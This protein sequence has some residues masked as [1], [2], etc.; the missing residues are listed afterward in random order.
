MFW[1]YF[2]L[3][4]CKVINQQITIIMKTTNLF[5][6]ILS[7]VFI[8]SLS[9]CTQETNLDQPDE[10]SSYKILPF[11]QN[12]NTVYTGNYK[13][14]NQT[15]SIDIA[16]DIIDLE[17]PIPESDFEL[18]NVYNVSS[19]NNA[20]ILYIIGRNSTKVVVNKPINFVIQDQVNI[21]NLGLDTNLLQNGNGLRIFVMNRSTDI[22]TD[23]TLFNCILDKVENNDFNTLCTPSNKNDSE[24]P[25]IV[26]DIIVEY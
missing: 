6:L 18:L 22:D 21:S 15:T 1:C 16:N 2:V 5:Q 20:A 17:I 11:S 13:V 4:I 25:D 12:K 23:S 14:A 19:N 7:L 8:L 3:Y 9:S 24:G 10:T 26:E